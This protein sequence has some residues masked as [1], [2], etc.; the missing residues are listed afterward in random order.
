MLQVLTGEA[1][2]GYKKK[3]IREITIKKLGMNMHN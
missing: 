3:K 2:K 1:E